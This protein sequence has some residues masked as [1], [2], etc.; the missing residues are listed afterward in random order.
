[1]K[2]TVISSGVQELIERIRTEGVEDAKSESKKILADANNQ[3]NDIVRDAEQQAEKIL[4]DARLQIQR[5]HQAA[6]DALQ[7]AYR[8]MILDIKGHLLNRFSEEVSHLVRSTVNQTEIL[9]TLVVEACKHLLSDIGTNS[10][11][12]VEVQLSRE[13]LDIHDIKQNPEKAAQGKIAD[14]AFS[15]QKDVLERGIFFTKR[16][17]NLSGIKILLNNNTV[18]V[19]VSD[20]A[21]SDLLLSY[22]NPRFRAVLDGIIH[23]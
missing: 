18:E 5:D 12:K 7:I 11:D 9:E 8:D 2:S 10:D 1:M 19:D 21:I 13:A 4:S 23:T 22:L 15:V 20:K 16:N 17:D 14:L 3:A 6:T